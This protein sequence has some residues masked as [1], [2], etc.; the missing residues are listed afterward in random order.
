MRLN[1]RRPTGDSGVTLIELLV[2]LTILAVIIAPLASAVIVYLRNTKATTDRMAE[3][4]DAQIAA[5]YF[6]HDVQSVGMRDWSAAPFPTIPSIELAVAMNATPYGCGTDATPVLARFVW[7]DPAVGAPTLR[8]A[9]Y[10]VKQV[11]GERQLRRVVC[12]PAGAVFS[13]VVLAHN[14]DPATAPT[15]ACTDAAGTAMACDTATLPASVT[16]TL[17]VRAPGDDS[18]YTVT[19]V[20]QRRQT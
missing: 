19:L 1:R 9:S 7:D 10:V 6:A 18:P 5:A 3:S 2:A 12:S 16:L 20:G 17:V 8:S 14:V 4:H 15:V 13:E 11:D